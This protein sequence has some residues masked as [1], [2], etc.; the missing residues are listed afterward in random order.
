MRITTPVKANVTFYVSVRQAIST[1]RERWFLPFGA[2]CS[3]LALG[4][5]R[6]YVRTVQGQIYALDE[7]LSPAVWV[8][9]LTVNAYLAGT[10]KL[11]SAM[12]YFLCRRA[13]AY[14]A[15][16]RRRASVT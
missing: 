11:L 13:N 1:A 9:T 7:E 12:E 10:C 2:V 6:L 3:D 4:R 5:N 16:C 14:A 8:F 15:V